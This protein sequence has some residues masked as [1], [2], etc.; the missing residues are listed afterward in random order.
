MEQKQIPL[1]A[2]RVIQGYLRIPAGKDKTVRC[3]YYRNPRSGRERWGL[4]AYSGKGSPQE[5]ADEMR[6]TEKL[7]GKDFSQMEERDIQE[8]MKKRKLGIDCSGFIAHVFD[9][10]VK[11]K[12]R[13]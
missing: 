2:E 7:E 10:W 11:E 3:P 1:A 8:A 6:N 13:K 4:N 9:A 5:I 12:K